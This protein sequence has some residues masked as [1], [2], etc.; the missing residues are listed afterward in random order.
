MDS[1]QEYYISPC[2]GSQ[3]PL[4]RARVTCT[5]TAL[6]LKV[7]GSHSKCQ[8]VNT[9]WFVFTTSLW[10]LNCLMVNLACI[11]GRLNSIHDTHLRWCFCVSEGQ[12]VCNTFW[13][14][15]LILLFKSKHCL[16]GY[17]LWVIV[18]LVLCDLL[19]NTCLW[20]IKY[21]VPCWFVF[22]ITST[23]KKSKSSMK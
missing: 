22:V 23:R 5:H 3:D 18:E 16:P 4:A 8:E 15:C 14:V 9:S 17:R 1:D 6:W 12:D 2:V 7:L 19:S 13:C 20:L 21:A 11:N 10:V